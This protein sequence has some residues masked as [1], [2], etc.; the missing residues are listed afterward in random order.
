MGKQSNVTMTGMKHSNHKNQRNQV[1]L[2]ITTLEPGILCV[3]V[4]SNIFLGFPCSNMNYICQALRMFLWKC[5]RN[6]ANAIY[7]KS[8]KKDKSVPLFPKHVVTKYTSDICWSRSA[9]EWS[10][11]YLLKQ[12]DDYGVYRLMT[13]TFNFSECVSDLILDI[14]ETTF[15]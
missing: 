14:I 4:P 15:S 7:Y 12:K 1:T 6:A 9:D 11:T 3:K 5:D 8:W 10:S 2:H 13:T